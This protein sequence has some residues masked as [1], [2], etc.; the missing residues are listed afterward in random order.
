VESF[1]DFFVKQLVA[2][3]L[4]SDRIC[5]DTIEKVESVAYYRLRL[6]VEVSLLQL[7]IS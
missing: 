5:V 2:R 7:S 3:E 1:A 4:V 6:K